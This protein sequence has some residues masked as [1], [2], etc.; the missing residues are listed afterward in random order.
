MLVQNVEGS[1]PFIPSHDTSISFF[2]QVEERVRALDFSEEDGSTMV[3]VGQRKEG[4][5]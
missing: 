2:V 1:S 5:R 4:A 3:S